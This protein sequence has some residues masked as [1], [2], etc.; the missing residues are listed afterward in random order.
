MVRREKKII[1]RSIS[2]Q[3]SRHFAFRSNNSTTFNRGIPRNHSIFLPP[4]IH[5]FS[6]LQDKGH[7]KPSE[8]SL[9]T[10]TPSIYFSG[11]QLKYSSAFILQPYRLGF[12]NP[13]LNNHSPNQVTRSHLEAVT[14]P[15]KHQFSGPL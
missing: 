1:L 4:A 6:F 15:N 5:E 11:C 2:G 3:L 9:T 12:A 7:L 8:K 13:S 14:K 10:Q